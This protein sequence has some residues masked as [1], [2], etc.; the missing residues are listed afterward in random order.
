MLL[1][2]PGRPFG[3]WSEKPISSLVE[4]DPLHELSRGLVSFYLFNDPINATTGGTVYDVCNHFHGVGVG[5]VSLARSNRG[6]VTNFDAAS[7]GRVRFRNFNIVGPKSA[8]TMAVHAYASTWVQ[9]GMLFEKE[10]VNASYELFLDTSS[11]L[12]L[13]GGAASPFA[14]LASVDA[15]FP[16][17]ATWNSFIGAIDSA[18]GGSIVVN[19]KQ[20]KYSTVAA[21]ADP[22]GRDAYVGCYDGSGYFFNGLLDCAGVWNRALTPD[23]GLIF[24]VNRFDFLRPRVFRTYFVLSTGT[25]SQSHTASGGI[26]FNGSATALQ[27]HVVVASG[28]LVTNGA[29]VANQR[30]IVAASGGLVF[31]GT[32]TAIVRKPWSATGGV[33]FAGAATVKQRHVLAGA[34]GIVFGGAAALDQRSATRAYTATGGIVF[35]GAAVTI[36]HPVFIPPPQ[37][38]F[39][40][41]AGDRDLR[42]AARE[43]YDRRLRER[44]EPRRTPEPEPEPFAYVHIASGGIV[45]SGEA[46]VRAVY[47]PPLT[48]VEPEPTQPSWRPI[49]GQPAIS[50][51]ARRPVYTPVPALQE[52]DAAERARRRALPEPEPVEITLSDAELDLVRRLDDAMLLTWNLSRHE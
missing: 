29:A 8:L 27:R 9:N 50:L 4:P 15:G 21:P 52:L 46:V 22:T 26:V 11:G 49:V 40:P 25:N 18:S 33:T 38:T 35:S 28:G 10:L 14:Q 42:R 20:R 3:R 1:R 36:N 48:F 17:A 43:R 13:R 45:F 37:P 47:V 51:R 39:Q 31:S 5:G 34:G 2:F 41:A 7:F 6:T 23:E 44:L 19:G 16:V 30:H 12:I 32:T 24:H